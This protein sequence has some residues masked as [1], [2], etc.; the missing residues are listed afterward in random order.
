MA[1]ETKKQLK[2]LNISKLNLVPSLVGIPIWVP[3]SP[4]LHLLTD[5]TVKANND[6]KTNRFHHQAI[7]LIRTKSKDFD[8]PNS[9]DVDTTLDLAVQIYVANPEMTEELLADVQAK[10]NNKSIGSQ[11]KTALEEGQQVIFFAYEV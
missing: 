4:E 3:Q 1:T 11:W 5:V 9:Y 8:I 10:F 7:G 6:G 2:K